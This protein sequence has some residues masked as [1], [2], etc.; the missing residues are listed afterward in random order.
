MM[1][2]YAELMVAAGDGDLIAKVRVACVVA[3]DDIRQNAAATAAQKAWARSVFNNPET[4]Q[5]GMLWS[6]LAQN[7]EAT[8]A[9]ILGATDAQVQAAVDA[10]VAL[11]S[12]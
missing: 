9:Q 12:E 11:F 2:T 5:M 4:P 3:A 6:V 8:L 7:R 1:A 10:S